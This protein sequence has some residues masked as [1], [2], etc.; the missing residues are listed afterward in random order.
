M[1]YRG[2]VCWGVAAGMILGAALCAVIWMRQASHCNKVGGIWDDRVCL[3]STEAIDLTVE[4]IQIG[5]MRLELLLP[6][7]QDDPQ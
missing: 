4:V 1:T 7:K 6:I 5:P 2:A 3:L